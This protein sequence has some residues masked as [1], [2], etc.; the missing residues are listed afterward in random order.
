MAKITI[1]GDVVVI[2]STNTLE[3]IKSLEKYNP[4]VLEL[5]DEKGENVI[6]KVGSTKGE[7]DIGKF[8][9][10]FGRVSHDDKKL[11]TITVKIPEE[12][13]DAEEYAVEE[14][15]LYI[16][17]LEKIEKQFSGALS[18]VKSV[19]ENIRNKITIA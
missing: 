14:F 9:A 10:S 4:G 2:T 11:A 15:G 6:F 13:E 18:D 16:N 3:D 7:G 12:V 5:R 17:N 1:A 8:G 19:K